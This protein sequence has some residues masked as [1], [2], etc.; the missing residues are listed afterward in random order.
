M[1]P[2][3]AIFETHLTVA[4]LPR[5]RDFY[6]RVLGLELARVFDE[7]RV[8]F[9]W[10]G[11]PG[12][13]MLGLGEAGSGPQRLSLHTAFQ[14]ALADLLAAPP[15]LRQ[16]GVTPLDFANQPTDEPVVLAWMPA[17]SL[18][19]QD[20]DGNLLE[21][22]CLLPDAPRPELG[23]LAWSDWQRQQGATP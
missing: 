4:D 12:R 10:V 6:G 11:A 15:L 8:A 1:I 19:F 20:P 9:Y 16:A 13:Q 5:A 2:I 23:V 14:V 21:Y 3:T 22:L 7:R 18:Y 17:A